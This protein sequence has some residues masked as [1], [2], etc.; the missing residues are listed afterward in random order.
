M[1]NEM[2]D[3]IPGPG[4]LDE[5]TKARIARMAQV[6]ELREKNKPILSQAE[7]EKLARSAQLAEWRRMRKEGVE[8]PQRLAGE[9]DGP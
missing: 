4:P 8:D 9:I 3:K 6:S 2:P 1:A 7:A 5:E